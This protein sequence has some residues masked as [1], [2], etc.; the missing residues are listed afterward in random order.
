MDLFGLSIGE[1]T[2]FYK[3][4]PPKEIEIYPRGRRVK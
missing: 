2:H 4:K 3:G 1:E